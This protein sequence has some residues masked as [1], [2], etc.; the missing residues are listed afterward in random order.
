MGLAETSPTL[1][2]ALWNIGP[3]Q[4]DLELPYPALQWL[5]ESYPFPDLVM[6]PWVEP[7]LSSMKCDNRY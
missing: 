6:E 4:E 5:T 7:P 1:M 3:R 2:M